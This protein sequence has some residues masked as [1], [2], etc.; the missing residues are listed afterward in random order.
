[1]IVK[2]IL[3]V[4]I[5]LEDL[6]KLPLAINYKLV[7]ASMILA[8]GGIS[9]HVQVISQIVDTKIKYVCFLI[10][11]LYQMIISGVITCVLCVLR[12]I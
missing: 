12:D 5:G 8:F 2:G 11:R 3:E 4:T 1:M 7:I 10:G 9:V 6:S